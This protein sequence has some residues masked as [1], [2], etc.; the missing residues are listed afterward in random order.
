MNAALLGIHVGGEGGA[1][2]RL[3][4]EEVAVL[5]RQ[6]RRDGRARR[7]ILDQRATDSPLSGAKAA[8]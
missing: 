3:V 8:M 4:E 6:D 5:R 1:E 2:L 7:R